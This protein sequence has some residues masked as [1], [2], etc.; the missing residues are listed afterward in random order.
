MSTSAIDLPMYVLAIRHHVTALFK[1]VAEQWNR[2]T[3]EIYALQHL[4]QIQ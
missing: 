4:Q 1:C 3:C 2:D